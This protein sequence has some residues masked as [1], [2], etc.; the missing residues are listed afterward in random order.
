MLR[1][2]YS[3]K[4]FST[5]KYP[6][7][8]SLYVNRTSNSLY[9]IV[10]Q[11]KYFHTGSDQRE[12]YI[13]EIRSFFDDNGNCK[14]KKAL[15]AC[16]EVGEVEVENV[17]RWLV[18][19]YNITV[20]PSS[21]HNVI[22]VFQKIHM[23]ADINTYLI[24]IQGYCKNDQLN[25]ALIAFQEAT[26]LGYK[27][28]ESNHTMLINLCLRKNNPVA[29]AKII[30]YMREINQM[31]DMITLHEFFKQ[32]IESDELQLTKDIIK[33]IDKQIPLEKIKFNEIL[34]EMAWYHP[35]RIENL[36]KMLDTTEFRA[37]SKIYTRL[38]GG[39][40]KT[41]QL[42]NGIQLSEKLTR[43]NFEL[44]YSQLTSLLS[45]CILQGDIIN[46]KKYM[47]DILKNIPRL[48][49]RDNNNNSLLILPLTTM[50]SGYLDNYQY[51]EAYDILYQTN[52]LTNHCDIILLQN[53]FQSAMNSNQY[54][55]S[56]D[57][58]LNFIDNFSISF[59]SKESLR[60]FNT[61]CENIIYQFIEDR[62]LDKANELILSLNKKGHKNQ[63]LIIRLFN[64]Y[65]NDD[66]EISN[67]LEIID[68]FEQMEMNFQLSHYNMMINKCLTTSAEIGNTDTVKIKSYFNEALKIFEMMKE[69]QISPNLSTFMLILNGYVQ[70]G[71]LNEIQSFTNELKE[72]IFDIP[73]SYSLSNICKNIIQTHEISFILSVISLFE[74]Q[75]SFIPDSECLLSLFSKSIE[76]NDIN[77][78]LS[79]LSIVKNNHS[80][81]IDISSF[82][83][84]AIKT[85]LDNKQFDKS[86]E[87]LKEFLEE[88]K[89]NKN[90]DPFILL[91]IF[92][93]FSSNNKINDF[94]H[95]LDELKGN[96][97]I[98]YTIFPS[99]IQYFITTNKN[100]KKANEMVDLLLKYNL[101]PDL[102]VFL[103]FVEGFQ[104]NNKKIIT[105][106]SKNQNKKLF[107]VHNN[108]N[109]SVNQNS[110]HEFNQLLNS[111]SLLKE[112]GLQE[113]P[114]IYTHLIKEALHCNLIYI[115]RD[116]F[117]EMQ[118]K[119]M[120]SDVSSL[121]MILNKMLDNNKI[122]D[123]KEYLDKCK[124]I[125]SSHVN[126][127]ILHCIDTQNFK[128]MQNYLNYYSNLNL[129]PNEKTI[130]KAFNKVSYYN[131]PIYFYPLLQF[132]IQYKSN[133]KNNL[134]LLIN[135]SPSI[136]NILSSNHDYKEK[137]N[138]IFN[139]LSNNL[140]SNE[141]QTINE[142]I[143]SHLL[144]FSNKFLL[145]SKLIY[146]YNKNINHNDYNYSIDRFIS[147]F[148]TI[149]YDNNNFSVAIDGF[150]LFS[151]NS[152]EFNCS[153]NWDRFFLNSKKVIIP[154]VSFFDH[155]K[156]IPFNN[157]LST[158]FINSIVSLSFK[159]YNKKDNEIVLSMW[160]NMF[161]NHDNFSERIS[162]ISPVKTEKLFNFFVVNKDF[163]N[164]AILLD[165]CADL[166]REKLL[167]ETINLHQESKNEI[168]N[169]RKNKN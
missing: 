70:N 115:A 102:S 166:N 40:V 100:Y 49:S 157:I 22:R 31:P 20:N 77:S 123:A 114:S 163:S 43:N 105:N 15:K 37:D 45:G 18:S 143:A 80:Q 32:I 82:Y 99:V 107:P 29:A 38:I 4:L 57:I 125:D 16:V 144:P 136:S 68:N 142:K 86:I 55:I 79:I 145:Y 122:S 13:N 5:C 83:K 124:N 120:Q 150:C 21:A 42:Q 24:I 65:I 147:N 110:F 113:S 67:F 93:S 54:E 146:E 134:L 39:Y 10:D 34:S 48:S 128:F 75:F 161:L 141:I 17:V 23:E 156:H 85:L 27:F 119:Q 73:S 101:K 169:L 158:D 14:R 6:S 59:Q 84:N 58:I 135:Y 148:F 159:Y 8:K 74:K 106:L 12:E 60:I 7:F 162:Y 63:Q 164:A 89:N 132:T 149:C 51:K 126:T 118:E 117:Y 137:F 41:N 66:T 91:S 167:S 94:L 72:N 168:L 95:L 88:N 35:N 81:I 112:K 103:A 109:L 160:N 9:N 97:S 155:L 19:F 151:S 152:N 26:N 133:F 47:D 129:F 111:I 69:K 90:D 98:H 64:S 121:Q 1:V 108:K 104:S 127:L 71:N 154:S 3:R 46:A 30:N 56:K 140:T 33:L 78:M 44:S 2:H 87:I 28:N 139:I 11:K 116:I 36:C 92:K 153:I 50:V 138:E 53:I 96:I 130:L 76:N 62:K 52:K 165:N 25:E 61:M 131:Q